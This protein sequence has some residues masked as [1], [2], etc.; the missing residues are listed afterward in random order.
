MDFL[1]IDRSFVSPLGTGN[2][3][4]DCIASAIVT[5]A[6]AHE[7]VVTAEGV[8]TE[9]QAAALRRMGCDRGQGWLFGRPEPAAPA[10]D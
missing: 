3:R 2:T 4:A 7:L 10:A 9:E 1:K 8:E 5:L 6:H